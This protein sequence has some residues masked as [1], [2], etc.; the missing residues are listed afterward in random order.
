MAELLARLERWNQQGFLIFNASEHPAAATVALAN[1]IAQWAIFLVPLL[2]AVLWLWGNPAN[3][4][5]L[6]LAFCRAEIAL[7]FNQTRCKQ[8]RGARLAKC[9][10]LIS[11]LTIRSGS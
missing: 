2:L 6:L 7:A 8:C 4:T 3:R 11:R 10:G 1:A 5:G 9:K